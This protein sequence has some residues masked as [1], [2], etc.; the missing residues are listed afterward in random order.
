MPND[1]QPDV[2]P[3]TRLIA[4]VLE[5]IERTGIAKLTVRGIAAA[6]DMNVA[7]VN[8]YYG[9]KANLVAEALQQSIRHM[10][11]DSIEILAGDEDPLDAWTTLLAYYLEG[12]LRFPQVTRAHLN[13]I[14]AS[15]DY[16]GTFPETMHTLLPNLRDWVSAKTGL[17]AEDAAARVVT[18]MSSVLFCATFP[19]VFAPMGVLETPEARSAYVHELARTTL[20]SAP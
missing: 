15:D 10:E 13:E 19:G 18:A 1:T 7:S 11:A 8:Y 6:A 12:S 2:D 17:A 20:S 3:A 9:S 14:F 16:S 4:A 5:E